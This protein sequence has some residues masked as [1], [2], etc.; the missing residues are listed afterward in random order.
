MATI[1]LIRRQL[2]R[3]WCVVDISLSCFVEKCMPSENSKRRMVIWSIAF[4]YY[5]L[6]NS[7]VVA[8]FVPV[9]FAG[10]LIA[11]RLF[12]EGGSAYGASVEAYKNIAAELRLG[13][14]GFPFLYPPFT[15]VLV[16]PFTFMPPRIA[17]WLW[18]LASGT[19]TI[20]SVELLLG[21]RRFRPSYFLVWIVVLLFVP[22]LSNIYTGQVSGFLLLLVASAWRAYDSD[23]PFLA[24]FLVSLAALMKVSPGILFLYFLWR[25][26]W[27]ACFGFTIGLAALAALTLPIVG[28][29]GWLEYVSVGLPSA[30]A[31]DLSYPPNTTINGALLRLLTEND[32]TRPLIVWP[33]LVR[34]L[35]IGLVFVVVAVT[36]WACGYPRRR[37]TT[38]ARIELPMI[39]ASLHLIAPF[40]WYH[41]LT[42][43]A[44]PI[45]VIGLKIW[46]VEAISSPRLAGL[47]IS[48]FAIDAFGLFWHHLLFSHLLLELPT[49]ALTA[50]WLLFVMSL[51]GFHSRPNS[52]ATG[53][54]T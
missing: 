24:G 38:R 44:L 4:F 18:G 6:F 33:K 10:Y 26:N 12:I 7:W 51:H 1:E 19:A 23:K 17:A 36:I 13:D 35:W 2:D 9:D 27:W 46:T 39:F 45:M 42:L 15:A 25:R 32:W 28:A 29:R 16:A 47:L 54:R 34:P 11:S 22:I 20:V 14:F 52:L 31:L 43:S 49:L 37:L 53:H 30:S 5:T 8:K 21:D 3:V 40:T 48:I 50:L 41:Q